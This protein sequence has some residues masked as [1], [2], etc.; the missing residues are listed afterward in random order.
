MNLPRDQRLMKGGK[1]HCYYRPTRTRLPDLPETHPEFVAAWAA[2]EAQA[3]PKPKAKAGTLDEAVIKAAQSR[4]FR[5]FSRSYQSI[6]RRGL[7][8][9]RT[10]HAGLPFSGL[11]QHHIKADLSR[12]DPNPANARLKAWRFLCAA[13]VDAGLIRE[14][15]SAGIKK[16][17]VATGGHERWTPDDVDAFR[18]RWPIGTSTRAC[19]ELVLCA[20]DRGANRRCCKD[21]PTACRKRWNPRFSA[22]QDGRAGLCS[23]D[24]T[25]AKL[26]RRMVRRSA[27]DARCP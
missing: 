16:V 1:L 22:I 8:H 9:I 13:A 19:F 27:V 7:D 12:L 17:R 14:N 21:G 4:A 24:R 6:I 10:E 3:R 2:A 25:S 26:R 5:A 15:P 20:V 23:M 18:A 11:R